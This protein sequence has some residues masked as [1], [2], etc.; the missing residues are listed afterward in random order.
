VVPNYGDFSD[1]DIERATQDP[2]RGILRTD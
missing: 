1:L 2:Y